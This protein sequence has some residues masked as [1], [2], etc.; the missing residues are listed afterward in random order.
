MNKSIA[1]SVGFN[2]STQQVNLTNSGKN[3]ESR[4]LY[5]LEKQNPEERLRYIINK[6]DKRSRV[7]ARTN[8]DLALS[9][10]PLADLKLIFENQPERL[11]ETIQ[12]D[13]SWSYIAEHELEISLDS[14][15]IISQYLR[16]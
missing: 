2:V 3:N 11:T 9:A 6:S 15:L 5:I 10:T 12:I 1:K 8:I 13:L 14:S 4:V 7:G 16:G